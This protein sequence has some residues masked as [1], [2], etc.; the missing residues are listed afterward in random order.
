M[1]PAGCRPFPQS[2]HSSLS[3]LFRLFHPALWLLLLRS[4]SPTSS[5]PIIWIFNWHYTSLN[6]SK[7]EFLISDSHLKHNVAI[8]LLIWV[9]GISAHPGAEVQS[10]EF[11]LVSSASYTCHMTVS[12]LAIP[13]YIWG[14]PGGAGSK[15]PASQCRRHEAQVESLAQEDPLE[16]SM[17]TH[18]SILAWRIPWTEE[19]G[20]LQSMGSHRVRHD[21]ATKHSTGPA[22]CHVFPWIITELGETGNY[23]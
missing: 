5:F 10:S 21:W 20:G 23:D 16:E 11:S 3:F 17:A 12:P 15:E 9:N 7:I 8:V 6:M 13:Q 22:R 2:L 1:L 4:I 18:S 14:F 19:P